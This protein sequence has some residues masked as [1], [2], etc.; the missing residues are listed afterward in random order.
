MTPRTVCLLILGGVFMTFLIMGFCVII[1]L[2]IF[3]SSVI[4]LYDA[5][6]E[7]CLAPDIGFKHESITDMLCDFKQVT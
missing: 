1:I 7:Y 2:K 4:I 6:L 5:F 3:T